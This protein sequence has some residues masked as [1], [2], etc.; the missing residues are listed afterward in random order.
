V[1]RQQRSG[2]PND[3]DWELAR[4]SDLACAAGAIV[5]FEIFLSTTAETLMRVRG[6]VAVWLD[7]GG[8]TPGDVLVSA[9]GLIRGP[10]GSS[11]V[12]VSP[13]TEG[14]ANFLAYGIVTLAT[15]SGVG[16]AAINELGPGLSSHRFLV[17]SKAMR[18]FRENESMYLIFETV[19]VN[20]AP[21]S[22]LSFALRALTAR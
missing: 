3:Y 7:P 17:D 19:S 5:Q 1:A 6:D 20:G 13:I 21:V 18:K 12:G 8:S 22:N 11:D 16:A 2:R 15:E 10:S 9:W 4:G 14:G